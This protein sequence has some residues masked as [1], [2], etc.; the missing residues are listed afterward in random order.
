MST[1]SIIPTPPAFLGSSTHETIPGRAALVGCP[2]DLTSTYRSGSDKAPLAI[3]GAS[4]SIETYSPFLDL[5]L[6]DVPFADLGDVPLQ[7]ETLGNALKKIRIALS[8]ILEAKGRPLCLGG[9]HT[10]TLPVVEALSA[11]DSGFVVV[12]ADAH[13]DLREKYEDSPL[14]HATVIRRVSEL[15]GP[16]RLI[17]VGIRSGTRDE[18]IWMRENGTL[19][20]WGPA[21]EKNL[22]SRIA[23]RPVYLTLDLDVL[24]PACFHATGNPEPGG[25]SYPDLERLFR[26][27]AGVTL[28]G[29]DI[30]ELNPTLDPSEV[31]TITAARIVRETLLILGTS[32]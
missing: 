15:L 14:N 24:D 7:N 22:L 28:L 26:V 32:G 30:V 8:G 25:W 9:E 5:D 20:Q 18:F 10:I 13:S 17:Q 16:N 27:L 11:S 6:V 12:H 31:G 3:R 19:L 1:K 2:L 4:D 21:A 23:G 29:A